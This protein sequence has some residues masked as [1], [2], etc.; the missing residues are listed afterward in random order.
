MYGCTEKQVFVNKLKIISGKP[1]VFSFLFACEQDVIQTPL[2]PYSIPRFF[3]RGI[4]RRMEV[5]SD[6]QQL[7]PHPLGSP[8]S[9]ANQQNETEDRQGGDSDKAFTDELSKDVQPANQTADVKV[10]RIHPLLHICSCCIVRSA[11]V[12]LGVSEYVWWLTRS[13]LTVSV[14]CVICPVL[15]CLWFN[16]VCCLCMLLCS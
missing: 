7:E 2:L 1:S 3:S 11:W 12:C 16:N 13:S 9:E 14:F 4:Q 5:P 8:W 6:V 10:S 15:P